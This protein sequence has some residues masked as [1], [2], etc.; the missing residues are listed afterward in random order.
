MALDEIDRRVAGALQVDGRASWRRIAG[1]IDVPVSTVVRRGNAL[2]ESG[3][4]RI[5]VMSQTRTVLLEVQAHAGDVDAVARALAA[6]PSSIF[7]YVLG[8]PVRILVEE[9]AS[10][11]NSDLLLHDIPA[12][13]GV[14]G[15]ALIPVLEYYRTLTSWMPGQLTPE[16]TRALNPA[17]GQVPPADGTVPALDEVDSAILA[18]LERDARAAAIDI[19]AAVGV[20]ESAVRRRLGVLIGGAVDVRAVVAPA[21]LGLP[22]AGFVWLRVRPAAVATVAAALQASPFVRYAA[23]TLADEQILVDVAVPTVAELRRFLTE[24]AWSAAVDGIRA[25]SVVGAYK[26]SGMLTR[27]V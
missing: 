13:P 5:G 3:D 27:E 23:F 26:R 24:S 2:L 14:T 1:V 4:V 22:I 7:V 8:S 9:H 12:I 6:R 10:E 21:V 11:E 17:F 15:V 25:A 18:V 16:E 20:S 19:A